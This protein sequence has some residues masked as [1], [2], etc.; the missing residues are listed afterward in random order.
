MIKSRTSEELT[1]KRLFA[2]SLKVQQEH[3]RNLRHVAGEVRERRLMKQRE[4]LE[5]M[6]NYY[7]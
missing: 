4:K 1:F 7:R 3:L 2:D 5:S 6:E